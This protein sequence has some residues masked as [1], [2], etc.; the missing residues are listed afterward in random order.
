VQK[1]E[2]ILSKAGVPESHGMGHSKQVLGHM[3]K[4]L[5]PRNSNF[6]I[7]DE[8]KLSLLLGALLHDADDRK[9][10]AKDS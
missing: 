7:S 6:N 8:R 2:E 5:E 3:M 1:L 9:Y 4:A 10:F